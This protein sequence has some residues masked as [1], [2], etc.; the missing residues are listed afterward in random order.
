MSSQGSAEPERDLFAEEV[1]E[2]FQELTGGKTQ[3]T[4]LDVIDTLTT[5]ESQSSPS[6]A[7]LNGSLHTLYTQTHCKCILC[8]VLV[9]RGGIYVLGEM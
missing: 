5:G 1:E 2:K 7:D 4:Q 6:G 9:Q 3:T 8:F